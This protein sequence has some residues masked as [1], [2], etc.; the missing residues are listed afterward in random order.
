MEES[1]RHHPPVP[2]RG[3][4]MHLAYRTNV[5]PAEDLDGIICQLDTY[6]TRVRR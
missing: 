2:A 3:Q 1:A 5:H 6:A 4:L